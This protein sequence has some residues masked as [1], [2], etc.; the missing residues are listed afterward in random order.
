MSEWWLH[1]AYLGYRSPVIVHSSP[2]TVG[3]LQKFDT[4]N[5]FYRYA[6]R[7]IGGICD[8]NKMIK[9]YS[10]QTFSIKYL[11]YN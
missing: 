4:S 2:G 11:F 3:P 10:L 8:Y 9:R 7:A 5:D 1:E 6:A